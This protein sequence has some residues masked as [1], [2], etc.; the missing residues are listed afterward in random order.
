MRTDNLWN[1]NALSFVTGLGGDPR[2]IFQK[3][4]SCLIEW[5]K[6]LHR[7]WLEDTLTIQTGILGNYFYYYYYY[8]Y[9][10]QTGVV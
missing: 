10:P 9:N 1:R 2:E 8:K 4:T 7:S 3:L 5:T 6:R